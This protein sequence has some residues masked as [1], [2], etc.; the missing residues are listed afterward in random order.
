M[1]KFLSGLRHSSKRIPLLLFILCTALV[2]GVDLNAQEPDSKKS[3]LWNDTARFLAG[4]KQEE[5]GLLIELDDRSEA[6]KH[7]AYFEK[8]WP[9]VERKNIRPQSDWA[10]SELADVRSGERFIFYPF[11]GPDFLNIGAFFPNGS[12]YVLF[13]LEPTGMPEDIRGLSQPRLS[14]ALANVQKTLGTILNYSFFRTLDMARDL[15]KDDLNGATPI[16]IAFMARTGNRVLDIQN[17]AITQSGTLRE[18]TVA[19]I[20][21]D[22]IA[23]VRIVFQKPGSD[24]PT[25]LHYFSLDISDEGL[26]TKGQIEAY[27]R[28]KGSMATYLKAASYLMYRDT[29]SRIRNLI[30]TKS[31][32]IMQDDSGMPLKSFDESIWDLTFY[33][34]YTTPIQLFQSRFQSDLRSVYTTRKNIRDLPF[35]IGYQWQKGSS[36]LMVARKRSK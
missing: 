32:F 36:N 10:R 11:S 16:L 12:E 34:T 24:Q 3:R 20:K 25:L 6:K 7:R 4:L 29:F 14:S 1:F 13:G 27:I 21:S 2:T 35:G 8:I 17:V 23:G 26:K 5:G 28:S 9:E 18:T 15:H 30:L 31:D 33:G 22:E 19:G